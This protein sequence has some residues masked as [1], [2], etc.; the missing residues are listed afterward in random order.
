[1]ASV[2]IWNKVSSDEYQAGGLKGTFQILRA[3]RTTDEK[4]GWHLNRLTEEGH[5]SLV[6][7]PLDEERCALAQAKE[8]AQNIHDR[9][10]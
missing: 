10:I 6:F 2:L 4:D 3:D 8:R 9:Y 1:M 5:A 7:F